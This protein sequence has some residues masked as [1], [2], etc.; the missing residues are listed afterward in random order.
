MKME[1]S[2][3][4][5]K[6]LGLMLIVHFFAMF[7]LMYSMTHSFDDVYANVNQA[8]MAALMVAPMAITMLFLMPSMYQ[9]KKLNYVVYGTS[10]LAL[11]IFFA[12][13]QAQTT[14]NDKQFL[15]SMIPHHSGA[16]LMCE[17]ASISDPQV[18]KL[19]GEI[20]ES[21]KREISEMRTI[22]ERL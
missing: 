5:Y 21:Q 14:V 8:Y 19:C 11:L 13:V 20:I 18:V 12:F 2:K 17:K 7:A 1:H 15:R 9:N 16:I 3:S 22:L 10:G 4:H 6:T